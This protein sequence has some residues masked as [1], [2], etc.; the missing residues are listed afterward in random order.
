MLNRSR[1][2]SS[3]FPGTGNG[4]VPTPYIGERERGTTF[5]LSSEP[6][7]DGG[8]E[9]LSPLS[10]LH[11]TRGLHP[12]NEASRALECAT[13]SQFGWRGAS[14]DRPLPLSLRCHELF[15]HALTCTDA[16][17]FRLSDKRCAR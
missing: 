1:E 3:S 10:T 5:S 16:M 12:T 17:G 4:N 8:Q 14:D 11:K 9:P 13:C 15:P 7:A 6:Q 2:R